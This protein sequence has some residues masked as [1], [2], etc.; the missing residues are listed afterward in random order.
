[1]TAAQLSRFCYWGAASIRDVADISWLMS[2]MLWPASVAGQCA[3][4]LDQAVQTVALAL[5][6]PPR[7]VVRCAVHITVEKASKQVWTRSSGKAHTSRYWRHRADADCRMMLTSL[8]SRTDH[9]FAFPFGIASL[10][11][12][13][14]GIRIHMYA[15]E[16]L[17]ALCYVFA[18]NY[19]NV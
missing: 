6:L 15:R 13:I 14:W 4:L 16:F 8:T 18:N 12:N 11:I 5:E 2:K 17:C 10:Q 19:T 7:F 3:S 9:Y 1:M